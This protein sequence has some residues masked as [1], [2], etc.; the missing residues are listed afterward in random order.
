MLHIEIIMQLYKD[1]LCLLGLA[2]IIIPL[3]ISLRFNGM[4][5]NSWRLFLAIIGIPTLMVTL[6]AARYPESPK[7]LVSQGKTD[8][9]L[10]ILRKIY[11]INTGRNEDDYPVS[12]DAT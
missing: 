3:P 8:E 10:A 5:Y 12:I 11:A 2:W 1:F 9:A 7:F 6:I 4:L